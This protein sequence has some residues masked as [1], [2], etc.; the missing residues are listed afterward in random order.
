MTGK[1]IDK[2]LAEGV[3]G[4]VLNDNHSSEV[5]PTANPHDD[6]D[7]C[8]ANDSD[9]ADGANI[10]NSSPV[11]GAAKKKKKK[12]KSNKAKASVVDATD[13]SAAS[14]Q[15]VKKTIATTKRAKQTEPP[16]I[17]VSTMFSNH[18]YPEGEIQEYKNDAEKRE[19][20]RLHADIYNDV[21]HAAEVHRQV[22]SYAQKKIQ[23]GMS[24][25][26]ICEMIENGTRT[27]IQEKG[28]DAGI[29]FPTGCSL[30]HVAAHYTP[31]GGDGTILKYDDVMKIDFGTHI[32][33]RIIDC[34]F[35]MAFNPK[36]NPLME[37][38]KDSTNTGIRESGIDVRLCD[39][40]AAV[41]E[42]MESYEVEIDVK[43]IRN[44]NG[45]SIGSY[46]IHAGKTVPIV[47]NGDQTMMEEGEFYAIETFG[48]TGRGLVHEDMECSHYMK[49]FDA[50]HI[51][52]RLPRSKQLLSTINKNFGTLAFCRR[53]LD[54]IG[55]TKYLMALKNLVDVGIVN[56][57][58][59]LCDAKGS[60]TAHHLNTNNNVRL[61][62]WIATENI[63]A[64]LHPLVAVYA[65][66]ANTLVADPRDTIFVS[67]ILFYLFTIVPSA[68]WLLFGRFTW[69]HAVL[70]AV[71]L[72][73]FTAPFILMLHC[74]CH[75]RI[76][77]QTNAPWL[78]HV[79]HVLLAPF[80]GETWNTFYYHHVKHHH[81]ED[82][83][84][85]DLSS[86]I[87]Y[88]RDN[89]V[90]FLVYFLRFYLFIGIELPLYFIRKGRYSQA[91]NCFVGE[92]GTLAFYAMFY[93]VLCP[94]NPAGV[95]FAWYV[96][97]NLARFGMM[98]GNWAQ[99]AFI[100]HSDPTNDYKSAITCLASFY[101]KN[102]FNDGY[103]TSHH[104]N[105]LRRWDDHPKNFVSSSEKYKK[106]T[107]V[108]FEGLDF[109]AVWVA[110][111]L[112]DY[113]TLADHFVQ[114]ADSSDKMYMSK[115]QLMA[116]LKR[117]TRRLPQDVVARHYY[118][119]T[120]AK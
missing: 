32:G 9:N 70:H 29:A 107:T 82:N 7:S 10:T 99:H 44:L 8:N 97:L 109:H 49:D 95:I 87:W 22:R 119:K 84:P 33:G 53:Y 37:A 83:G 50:P 88:D 19:Q 60:Y 12:K 76:G 21:R 102:C 86:T 15:P 20:E 26:E 90:H 59:P 6:G 98:S 68:L 4:I 112:K 30:N 38:I 24:M 80:F 47:D 65:S 48:S 63:P 17:P 54:R 39:V 91:F 74:L 101:N 69:I 40:G 110:L 27:L 2:S 51:P 116:Y 113:S 118:S 62:G 57:Y 93:F 3:A 52:L 73:I 58:P 89:P 1:P 56:P 61:F 78:D 14:A 100:E 16:S 85:D 41:Q 18:V 72:G 34:A 96:P 111:M 105:P 106:E 94:S 81:V 42:V 75:R 28:L 46:Q 5:T 120:A 64:V 36:F 23:P 114:L 45:H 25:I 108:V 71:F 35:T 77:H 117:R 31:N 43:P 55:E 79:V 103:H 13:D 92:Y 67:Y 66:A 11:G 115:E 104:L